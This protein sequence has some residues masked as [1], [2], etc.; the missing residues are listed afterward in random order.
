MLPSHLR[1][2]RPRGYL[3]HLESL[4]ERC[5][6]DGSTLPALLP[7]LV[8]SP[9]AVPVVVA[10]NNAAPQGGSD[11]AGTG[12]ASAPAVSSDA[13]GSPA[14]YADGALPSLAADTSAAADGSSDVVKA[15]PI[16]PTVLKQ[17]ALSKTTTPI[18]PDTA[19]SV[20]KGDA[21]VPGS[22]TATMSVTD[23]SISCGD[24]STEYTAAV[25][26]ASSGTIAHDPTSVTA[27]VCSVATQVQ[28]ALTQGAAVPVPPQ[29]VSLVSVSHQVDLKPYFEYLAPET[30]E[31]ITQ[32]MMRV[33][34]LLDADPGFLV[35][36]HEQAG[37]VTDAAAAKRAG[38]VGTRAQLAVEAA[39][40]TPQAPAS[41]AHA[42]LHT[43]VLLPGDVPVE[44][45]LPAAQREEGP[46]EIP[47]VRD[48]RV[49]QPQLLGQ[50]AGVLAG[51]APF[52]PAQVEEAVGRLFQQLDQARGEM[53]QWLRDRGELLPWLTAAALLAAGEVTRRRRQA[54]TVGGNAAATVP[55]SYLAGTAPL[56]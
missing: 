53:G 51:F 54:R 23:G 35:P 48:T 21:P 42:A 19:A 28:P 3:P 12:N 52:D 56:P 46:A 41:L 37:T 31:A 6:L 17:A 10:V 7:P 24:D 29:I 26:A 20:S 18:T 13:S 27:L 8:P 36:T 49:Q 9:S 50:G 40:E 2:R 1:V 22:G 16:V 38:V 30:R 5:L 34:R 32:M 14:E 44:Q 15:A 47:G 39:P 43:A 55:L 11:A 25:A 4:E 33:S 45:P